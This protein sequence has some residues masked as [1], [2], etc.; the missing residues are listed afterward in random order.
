MSDYQ[1]LEINQNKNL[2]IEFNG[3]LEKVNDLAAFVSSG[4]EAV[5]EML[6]DAA[7][8]RGV[9]ADKKAKFQES[10]HNIVMERDITPDKL[11][12]ASTLQF[13]LPKFSG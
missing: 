6:A 3:I 13:E 9:V 4:E 12:N 8:K 11:K 7:S 5:R 2:D 1:I 10:L